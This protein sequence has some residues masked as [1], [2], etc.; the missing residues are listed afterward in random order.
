MF[1]RSIYPNMLDAHPPFQI[2]GNF[3][4]TAAICEALLQS[5][6]DKTRILPA[7]PNEWKHGEIRG[8]VTRE[9]KKINYKW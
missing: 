2:D 5:H 8:F 3:G 4:I 7:L 1:A 9:G 6:T